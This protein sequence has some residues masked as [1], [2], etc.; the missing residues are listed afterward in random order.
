MTLVEDAS[1]EDQPGG[2]PLRGMLAWAA[3]DWASNAFPTI[4]QTFLFASYFA[5]QVAESETAGTT[6]WGNTLGVAGLIVAFG[7]PMLGAL[8][9]QLGRRKPWIAAFTWLTVMAAALMWF[10]RPSP[11]YVAPALLLV[12]LGTIG[13]EFAFILYN[14]MLPS[15]VPPDKVGRWSGWGWGAGYVGGLACLSVA[16]FAFVRSEG[17]WLRLDTATAEHV[18]A[19]FPMTAA[20]LFLFSLPLLLLAP[21]TRR[22]AKTLRRAAR[23]A[24][25]QLRDSLRQ[26]RRYLHVIRF[27]IAR[28]FYVDALATLFAFGGVYA[29]GTF[30]MGPGEIL[31][32]GI[33][34]NVA[35][36]LGALGFAW[37]DDWIGGKRTIIVALVGLIVPGTILLLV[38]S[39]VQFWV[40][41]LLLGVF[42][43][44]AQAG[45]RS[46]LA[47]IA[48]EELQNEAFGL[49]AFSG[50]ATAFV[51]PLLVGWLTHWWQSQRVGMSAVIGLLLVGLAVLITVPRAEQ[52]E[53]G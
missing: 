48:P 11:D 51:G 12:G 27:L 42:V 14:A 7:G 13:S 31:A 5:G 24:L 30:G 50:K 45:S 18:R 23:D 47:R 43:G 29:R 44:P 2:P 28:M 35:A 4:I 9:D 19:V 17:A 32:F 8:V 52:L 1:R 46:H 22:T 20:W 36:G 39:K 15:L 40:F 6:W 16:L 38:Q 41:A 33:G 49:Y 3:Y 26:V 37:V 21:D 25:G 53:S 10:I 34:L